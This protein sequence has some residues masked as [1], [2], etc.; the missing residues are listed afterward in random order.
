MKCKICDISF[1]MSSGKFKKHLMQKHSISDEYY[2]DLHINKETN[3]KC[4][5]GKKKKFIRITK[6]YYQSCGNLACREK[7]RQ[8]TSKETN[9]K[10][11]GV[12]FPFQSKEIQEK[13][14]LTYN[15][16]SKTE[17]ISIHKVINDTKLK[18]YGFKYFNLYK[19]KETNQKNLGVD[20]PFQSKEIQEKICTNN[21]EKYGVRNQFQRDEIKQK[22]K[23]TKKE[24]YDDENYTNREKSEETCIKKYGVKHPMHLA[25]FSEKCN[26]YKWKEY[27]FPSGKIIKVQGYEPQA[28]DILLESYDENEIEV[29]RKKIPSIW[30]YTED[31]KKHRYYPDIYIEKDNLII[32]VKSL[33]TF[34]KYKEINLL[35]EQACME[36]GYE[37]KFM[38]LD[39]KGK[40]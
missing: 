33:W 23:I 20:F 6:G 22:S 37:F 21:E 26:K 34:N 38:I 5:C 40:L 28:L 25:E 9:Q 10:N 1:D 27:K 36:V 24:L 11:L 15:N 12:D 16:K 39:N 4:L 19:S 35:K 13:S 3:L 17:K 29:S 32:E 14:N 31:E 8:F 2:Y 30:Y 7:Q 18:K